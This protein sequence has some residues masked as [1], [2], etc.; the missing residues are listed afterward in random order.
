MGTILIP[1]PTEEE[2]EARECT[3]LVPGHTAREWG[4][5]DKPFHLVLEL[6]GADCMPTEDKYEVPG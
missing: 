2:G 4:K 6:M 5:Q 1:H 3:S